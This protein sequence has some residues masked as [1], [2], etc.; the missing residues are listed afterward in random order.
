MRTILYPNGILP[1]PYI[2]NSRDSDYTLYVI[3]AILIIFFW[4]LVMWHFTKDNDQVFEEC[5]VGECPT[6]MKTGQKRCS[7]NPQSI[8][9][10]DIQTETCNPPTSCTNNFTP[11]AVN[12][13]GSF[14]V[15]GICDGETVCRCTATVDC[16]VFAEVLFQRNSNSNAYL[17]QDYYFT[18][19]AQGSVTTSSGPISI[20]NLATQSCTINI[21]DTSRLGG[22][23]TSFNNADDIY[24]CVIENPCV[25]GI[26]SYIPARTRDLRTNPFSISKEGLTTPLACIPG[27][28]CVTDYFPVFDWSTGTSICVRRDDL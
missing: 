26:F 10:R 2:Q 12:S 25:A 5:P 3:S 4:C 17:S 24:H 1:D 6:N 11:Y 27:V 18:Q 8:L 21:T 14:N 22:G 28:K 13:D 19:V 16:P 15:N 23:C 7:S 9:L 20:D